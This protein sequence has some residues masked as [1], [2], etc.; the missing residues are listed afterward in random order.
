MAFFIIILGNTFWCLQPQ[1]LCHHGAKKY[2]VD[3]CLRRKY[4]D[5]QKLAIDYTIEQ[6]SSIKRML[7]QA[8]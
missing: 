7:K 1:L 8:I 5:E 6:T 4:F 3:V 2:P